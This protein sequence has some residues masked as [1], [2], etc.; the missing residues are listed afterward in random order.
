[1][2]LITGQSALAQAALAWAAAVFNGGTPTPPGTIDGSGRGPIVVEATAFSSGVI[3]GGSKTIDGSGRGP[4][5]VE[6]TAFSAGGALSNQLGISGANR[7]PVVVNAIALHFGALLS[8]GAT[9]GGGG[10]V[11][12]GW[13]WDEGADF[14]FE[15]LDAE[16]D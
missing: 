16:V 11:G 13:R 2:A 6:A 5:V 4:I 10:D 15:L 7:A 12:T 8:G 9:P 3:S 14:L 1:M